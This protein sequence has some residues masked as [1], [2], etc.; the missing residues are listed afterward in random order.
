MRVIFMGTPNFAV[1][2][3]RK[4]HESHHEIT[5]VVTATDKP[6]GRGRKIAPSPVKEAALEM[7]LPVLQPKNLKSA[8]FIDKL[9]N[10]NPDLITVVAFRILPEEVFSLPPRGSINLHA[11]LLPR[12]RG[13]APINWALINGDTETGLTTFLLNKKV[14]TGAILLQR[15]IAIAPDD[16][17]GSLHDKLMTAGAD[18]LLET[19]DGLESGALKPKPQSSEQA[20]P[21]PKL[22]TETGRISWQQPARDIVNLIRGLAPQPGA[23][24]F[25]D[26]KK[27]II[28]KGRELADDKDAEPGTIIKAD[29]KTGLTIK[30]GQGAVEIIALKPQGKKAMGS[31]EYVRGNHVKIGGKFDT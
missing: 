17:S 8:N 3:L 31:E 24:G 13:A 6:Q 29:K 7:N 16:D 14:D 30:C 11:S 28:L 18:L 22:T 9:K 15:R 5:A 4:L 10:F 20:S 27:I 19:I 25:L 23:Y 12:Y 1:E 26:G 2:S 21:A